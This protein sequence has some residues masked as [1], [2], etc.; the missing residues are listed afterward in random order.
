MGV[1]LHAIQ[2]LLL[3]FVGHIAATEAVVQLRSESA[4]LITSLQPCE[5]R[6]LPM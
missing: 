2:L 4:R 3:A 6:S 1:E 5:A